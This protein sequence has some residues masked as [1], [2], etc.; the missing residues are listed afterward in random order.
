[1]KVLERI[2]VVCV[3]ISIWCLCG[4]ISYGFELPYWYCHYP[5]L[6]CLDARESARDV[7]AT[8]PLWLIPVVATKAFNGYVWTHTCPCECPQ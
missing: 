6:G 3:L 4:Y 7:A 5:S 1:M 2:L 8:G